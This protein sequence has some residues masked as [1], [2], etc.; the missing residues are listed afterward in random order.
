M[1]KRGILEHPKT[2]DLAARLD[3]MAPYAVGLLEV[4][5][6]WVAKYHPT[7]DISGTRPRLMASSIRYAGN[8]E[9]LWQALIDCGWIEVQPDQAMVHDWSEHA[10]D[11]VRKLLLRRN[12]TFADGSEPYARKYGHQREN[13]ETIARHKQDYSARNAEENT[14]PSC[15]PLPLPEPIPEPKDKTLASPSALPA[16]VA[17]VLE[18]VNGKGPKRV[19]TPDVRFSF[20]REAIERYWVKVNPGLPMPW[21][22]S[23]AKRL[24]ELLRAMPKLSEAAFE[25]ML[26]NRARSEISQ[27]VRPRAW[28]ASICDYASGPLDRY[29]KPM[30][31]T[32][33]H[34]EASIGTNRATSYELDQLLADAEN[35]LKVMRPGEVLTVRDVVEEAMRRALEDYPEV[36]HD[37][38]FE[39]MLFAHA[40]EAAAIR[41]QVEEGEN[42]RAEKAYREQVRDLFQLGV[43][44]CQA[45]QRRF[46]IDYAKAIK[47]IDRMEREGLILR[48]DDHSL[49]LGPAP[50][51][52]KFTEVDPC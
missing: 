17:K 25:A 2:L 28:L 31:Q 32:T 8:P 9:D 43:A 52:V 50:E 12:E 6:Q 27:S 36:A 42:L 3:I 4:F 16:K 23:E 39:P 14:P 26:G 18:H 5:W 40:Q 7:G 49:R 30:Q 45:L 22:G 33:T 19:E 37:P 46:H 10:D 47:T 11:T 35:A 44:S 15:L 20:F 34:P 24:N 38:K 51:W 41:R 13:V 21:D 29:R 1:A 48:A